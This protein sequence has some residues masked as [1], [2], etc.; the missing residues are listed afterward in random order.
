MI[1]TFRRPK[2]RHPPRVSRVDVGSSGDEE[3]HHIYRILSPFCR[4]DQGGS[5]KSIPRV[6]VDA[7]FDEKPSRAIGGVPEGFRVG[8]LGCTVAAVASACRD[9]PHAGEP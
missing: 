4:E 6:G 8:G 1:P 2:R 5:A 3:T 9:F 7:A